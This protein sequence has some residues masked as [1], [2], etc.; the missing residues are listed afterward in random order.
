M[1][2]GKGLF[3]RECSL[4]NLLN[5]TN[6]KHLMGISLFPNLS[7]KVTPFSAGSVSEW[8]QAYSSWSY[9]VIR[10]GM[11]FVFTLTTSLNWGNGI[12]ATKCV[13]ERNYLFSKADDVYLF[14]TSY[15][16]RL[17]RLDY[18]LVLFHKLLLHTTYKL[19]FQQLISYPGFYM[20]LSGWMELLRSRKKYTKG[21][22]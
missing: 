19:W 22:S 12:W 9:D 4:R 15:S 18:Y 13:L 21:L 3:L 7:K 5:Q 2:T 14:Y 17:G 20:T 1:G 11:I 16:G 6:I 10:S 8:K